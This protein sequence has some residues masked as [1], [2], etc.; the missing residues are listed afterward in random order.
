VTVKNTLSDAE[1]SQN[2]SKFLF[3]RD[4]VDSLKELYGADASASLIFQ[5]TDLA[6]DYVIE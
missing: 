2:Y 1:N 5:V 6:I 3:T 4:I